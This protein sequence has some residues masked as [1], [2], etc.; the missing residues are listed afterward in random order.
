[1]RAMLPAGVLPHSIINSSGCEEPACV[2]LSSKVLGTCRED[3]SPGLAEGTRVRLRCASLSDDPGVA[4]FEMGSGSK[5]ISESK[6][7]C[8]LRTSSRIDFNVPPKGP[9]PLGLS[10]YQ[11]SFG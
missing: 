5:T 3:T 6:H 8:W 10:G 1:M 9:S 4:P 7:W 2:G 11:V